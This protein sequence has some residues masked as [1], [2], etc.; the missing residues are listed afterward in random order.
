MT[1][2]NTDKQALSNYVTGEW[3]FFETPS[4]SLIAFGCL[5]NGDNTQDGAVFGVV[6]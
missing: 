6:S 4:A 3:T 1:Q 5:S 2:T